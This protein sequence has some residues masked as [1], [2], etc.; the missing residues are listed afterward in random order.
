MVNGSKT[1]LLD[2]PNLLYDWTQKLKLDVPFESIEANFDHFITLRNLIHQCFQDFAYKREINPYH[3]QA[4][5]D[6]IQ[7]SG[8]YPQIRPEPT[9]FPSLS[10]ESKQLNSPLLHHIVQSFFE[11]I[12]QKKNLDRLKPCENEDCILLF[13][14][15]SK[16][17][18]RRWCSMTICGNKIKASRFYYRNRRPS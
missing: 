18:T 10:Y 13:L 2:S 15:K 14:D 9:N 16:N 6:F 12:S 7:K 5:N 17:K 3:L 11:V 8:I 4:V 1:D